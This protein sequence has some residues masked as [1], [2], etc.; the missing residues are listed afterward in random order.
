MSTDDA[1]RRLFDSH[2]V[3][4]AIWDP[5][6]GRILAFNDA[7]AHQYGY[8]RD[9]ATGLRVD[10]LIH[11]DDAERLGRRLATMP[12]GHVGGETF[13]HVRRDRSVIEVEMTGHE[14]EFEGRPA[15]VVM[16]LDVTERRALEE[17]LRQ[18][19]RMEAVGHL[20]GGIA[21][22]FNNLLMVI[23]GF[24]ELLVDRLE[25]GEELEAAEQIQAAGERAATLTRKLLA[26]AEPAMQQPEPIDLAGLVDDLLPELRSSAGPDV[27]LVVEA[28]AERPWVEADRAEL[29]QALL[30]LV[31][32]GRDA[33]VEP[34]QLAISIE[35]ASPDL[36][37]TIVATHGAVV[38]SVSDSGSGIPEAHRERIFL[39]FFTTRADRGATGLGLALVFATVRAAGGRVWVEHP[40][41]GGAVVRVLLPR[42]A[43]RPGDPE[44]G[45]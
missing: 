32:N 15:R 33:M 29:G 21:H 5:A 41:S 44:P 17:R 31:A 3:P 45:A 10:A 19:Q 20:A 36:A 8:A 37:A 6:D 24:S 39:P 27:D 42:T 22:D 38:L 4:M 40:E 1:Y 28:P 13:R 2:P 23:N 11:P 34:G 12:S 14:L 9:E 30:G 7:A 43:A 35:D 16:A 26:F 18:A 25:P